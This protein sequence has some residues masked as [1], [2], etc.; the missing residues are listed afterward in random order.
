ML[1]KV[2]RWA[3]ISLELIVTTHHNIAHQT[4][5][6]SVILLITSAMAILCDIPYGTALT[7][8]KIIVLSL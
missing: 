8:F 5:D 4:K 2:I 3:V 1:Y 7:S 6:T